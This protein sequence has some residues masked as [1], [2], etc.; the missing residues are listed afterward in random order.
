MEPRRNATIEEA[1]AD[2]ERR[3]V[4]A[5]PNSLARYEQACRVMPGG[6][7]RSV[8][9]FDPFPVTLASGEGALV[10]DVD[11]HTYLDL[12]GEFTAGLYG[13]SNPVIKAAVSAAPDSGIVLGGP[14]SPL[15]KTELMKHRA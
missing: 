9:H 3:Y 7:T 14:N 10:R 15:K 1:V 13:H 5:H 6:N 8:L 2:A 12:L 11:D 4:A